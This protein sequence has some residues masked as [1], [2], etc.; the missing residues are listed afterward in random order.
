MSVCVSPKLKSLHELDLTGC[1]EFEDFPEI[2]EPIGHLN[3]LSLKGT[4]IKE[5]PSSIECL[6]GLMTIELTNCKR[7]AHL[8]PTICK[9]KSLPELDLTGCSEFEDF[10]EI[11]EPMKDMKFLSLKGTAVKE[12]L[13]SIEC[14][15]G[16]IKIELKNCK[17]FTSLPTS[18]C[19]LES[20]TLD[21][22]GCYEF[23]DFPEIL[24]PMKDMKIFH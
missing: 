19:K 16:L 4:A 1:S 2:L 22:S 15:F 17:K 23:E 12:L 24:E 5:L 21:L 10:P 7:L 18:I 14:L 20:L 6:F 3:I 9:L 13:S 11:L 8:P